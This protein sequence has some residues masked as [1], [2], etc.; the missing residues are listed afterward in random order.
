MKKSLMF[1][2]TYFS[3]VRRLNE[4]LSPFL[5]KERGKIS[6]SFLSRR[7]RL[8]NYNIHAINQKDKILEYLNSSYQYFKIDEVRIGASTIEFRESHLP[9]RFE[10]TKDYRSQDFLI[11][12]GVDAA[13]KI[14]HLDNRTSVGVGVFIPTGSGKTTA[15]KNILREAMMHK[16]YSY[17]IVV[18]DPKNQGDF[19]EFEGLCTLITTLED[20]HKFFTSLRSE[21]A[22]SSNKPTLIIFE[23]Y[24]MWTNKALFANDKERQSKAQEIAQCLELGLRTYRSRKVFYFV[25]SQNPNIGLA[26]IDLSNLTHKLLGYVSRAQATALGI[27][28]TQFIERSDLR[29]GKFLYLENGNSKLIRSLE[30]KS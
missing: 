3:Q 12:I 5:S 30:C 20:A 4:V 18:L 28:E 15:V 6:L 1:Y 26:T 11:P 19:E 27:S 2:L 23:E 17:D 10:L 8:K 16:R 13:G 14:V 9:A 25:I 22:S 29:F 24:L 21:V 7:I